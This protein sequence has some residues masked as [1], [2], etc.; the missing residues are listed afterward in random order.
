VLRSQDIDSAV[1]LSASSNGT[2]ISVMKQFEGFALQAVISS[3]SSLNG[4]LKIQA[5][6]DS[7][8][9]TTNWADIGGT[10]ATVIADGVTMW[11]IGRHHFKYVRIV[12]TRTAGSGTMTTTLNENV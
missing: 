2:P 10:T 9:S 8:S 12:W 3:S 7:G 5:N 6:I 4:T 11:S 1:A